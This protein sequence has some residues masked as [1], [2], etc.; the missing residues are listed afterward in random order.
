METVYAK[1]KSL[2]IRLKEDF[3]FPMVDFKQLEQGLIL[4]RNSYTDTLSREQLRVILKE[5]KE[6]VSK[7]NST[8]GSGRQVRLTR[9]LLNW[10]AYRICVHSSLK[11]LLQDKEK[12]SDPQTRQN[13]ILEEYTVWADALQRNRFNQK[14]LEKR[15]LK[16]IF[17]QKESVGPET[18]FSKPETNAVM[19]THLRTFLRKI[20]PHMGLGLIDKLYDNFLKMELNSIKPLISQLAASLDELLVEL[21]IERL[22]ELILTIYQTVESDAEM[23]KLLSKAQKQPAKSSSSNELGPKKSANL[24]NDSSLRTS[25]PTWM[26]SSEN[27]TPGSKGAAI[28]SPS[29]FST[30]KPNGRISE[31]QG[32]IPT[33]NGETNTENKNIPTALEN[34]PEEKPEHGLDNLAG[35]SP[36]PKTS[37]YRSR[38]SNPLDQDSKNGTNEKYW[39]SSSPSNFHLTTKE[40]WKSENKLASMLSL[41]LSHEEEKRVSL[42]SRNTTTG[43]KPDVFHSCFIIDSFLEKIVENHKQKAYKKGRSAIENGLTDNSI[44]MNSNVPN[45]NGSLKEEENYSRVPTEECSILSR[46]SPARK[47][48]SPKRKGSAAVKFSS[49]QKDGAVEKSISADSPPRLPKLEK[50]T[51]SKKRAADAFIKYSNNNEIALLGFNFDEVEDTDFDD[52]QF[53]QEKANWGLLEDVAGKR[54]DKACCIA[55]TIF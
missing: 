43:R 25:L 34:L 28:F 4:L 46:Q 9:N 32:S 18:D 38:P 19:R 40:K 41:N 23:R 48:E 5:L 8:K 20:F 33:P 15:F 12:Y 21:A 37:W 14:E 49:E 7:R 31:G 45:S 6:K 10:L 44:Q 55:C 22:K 30:K 39:F 26:P 51:S 16:F 52:L 13:V 17:N 2:G 3:E 54:R 11:S 29:L 24:S 42:F 27:V 53:T 1:L 47:K 36:D 50:A 35:S